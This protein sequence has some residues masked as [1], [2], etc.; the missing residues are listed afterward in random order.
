MTALPGGTARSRA[1]KWGKLKG[2][3]TEPGKLQELR[4]RKGG[5]ITLLTMTAEPRE[6]TYA[7]NLRPSEAGMIALG[8]SRR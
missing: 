5:A 7:T 8:W 1:R 2:S 4:Q 3:H 6:Y